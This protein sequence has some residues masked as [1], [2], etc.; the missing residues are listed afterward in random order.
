MTSRAARGRAQDGVGTSNRTGARRAVSGLA[1]LAILLLGVAALV[2][3]LLDRG[4]AA[5]PWLVA[6]VLLAH[7]WVHLVY[8]VPSAPVRTAE[9]AASNP[10]D[11]GRS[12]LV[13]RGVDVRAVRRVGTLLALATFLTLAA[14]ALAV[15]GWLVPAGW[16]AALTLTGVAASTLLLLMSLASDLVLGFVINAGLVA[17]AVQTTWQVHR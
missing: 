9:E 3:W 5:A 7:G 8:L 16:W 4:S 2:W 15:L 17:L 14:A 12:W 1:P 6:A 11:L 10:F 13:G